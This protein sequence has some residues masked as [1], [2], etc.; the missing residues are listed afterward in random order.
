MRRLIMI[1][2][3]S[4]LLLAGCGGL[5]PTIHWDDPLT[6]SP[7]LP[8]NLALF[9]DAGYILLD[10]EN[11]PYIV[12]DDSIKLAEIVN[13][14]TETAVTGAKMNLVLQE[15]YFIG[16]YL[17]R[18]LAVSYEAGLEVSRKTTPI[19]LDPTVC[20]TDRMQTVMTALWREFGE[21]ITSEQSMYR[22]KPLDVRLTRLV[23]AKYRV[24][25]L[26]FVAVISRK[27]Q[28]NQPTDTPVSALTAVKLHGGSAVVAGLVR[29]IDG[30]FVYLSVNT[31][32]G[33]QRETSI[34]EAVRQA[35]STLPR[36]TVGNVSFPT[37]SQVENEEM[38]REETEQG[39]STSNW[40]PSPGE[41]S[42]YTARPAGA[43]SAVLKGR[44]TI[45]ILNKPMSFAEPQAEVPDGTKVLILRRD[46]RWYLVELPDGQRGWV[47][48]KWVQF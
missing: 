24:D 17:D 37:P 13:D 26:A 19:H 30:N 7:S 3:L 39:G 44:E 16:A 11:S 14:E 28:D 43:R 42:D 4:M 36:R 31:I 46:M 15:K 48:E 29:A 5:K 21:R 9:I 1:M 6:G 23:G 22:T 20:R 45:T 18:E 8:E 38:E 32:Q 27:D 25:T 2:S 34:R 41:E 35:F 40:L 10:A 47:F 33:P 12:I